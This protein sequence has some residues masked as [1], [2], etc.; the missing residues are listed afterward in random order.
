MLHTFDLETP[1]LKALNAMRKDTAAE[2][3]T[4]SGGE[5][6]RFVDKHS[7][8]QQM[9]LL[10]NHIPNRYLL[11]FRPTANTLG[12]HTLHLDLPAHTEPL[13]ISARTSYWSTPPTKPTEPA[14]IP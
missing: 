4:L 12:F 13:D 14:K 11:C 10:A 2:V 9:S 8:E 1:L 7:L 5:H 3:A 6:I